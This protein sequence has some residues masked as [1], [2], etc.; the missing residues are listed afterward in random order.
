MS[1]DH[2]YRITL[3]NAASTYYKIAKSVANDKILIQITGVGYKLRQ[4]Y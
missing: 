2:L 3:E 1:L 4:V